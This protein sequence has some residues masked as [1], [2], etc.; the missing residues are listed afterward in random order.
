M[1]ERQNE[2]ANEAAL[3]QSVD[4]IS[5]H[6][7]GRIP[8]TAR[9]RTPSEEHMQVDFVPLSLVRRLDELKT[10]GEIVRGLFWTVLGALLGV[11]TS[12]TISD[13]SVLPISK[14]TWVAVFALFF[15]GV[16]F[17]ALSIRATQKA[18][19][20]KKKLYEEAIE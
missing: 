10:D 20:A 11:L 12:L 2:E 19:L 14:A 3:I 5:D 4:R 18:Q 6:L 1:D 8:R 15:C 13:N 17:A 9:I 7:S 16:V